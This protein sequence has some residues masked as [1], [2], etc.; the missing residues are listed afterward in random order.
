M[1]AMALQFDLANGLIRAI[2]KNSSLRTVAGKLDNRDIVFNEDDKRK[3]N[4]YEQQM[5]IE[6]LA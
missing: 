3:L 1:Q 6:K 2:R 5:T 4:Y